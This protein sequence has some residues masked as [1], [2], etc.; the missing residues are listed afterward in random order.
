[1]ARK[2]L[3]ITLLIFIFG[4]NENKNIF[5]EVEFSNIY[6]MALSNNDFSSLEPNREK[7]L[8]TVDYLNTNPILWEKFIEDVNLKI[9]K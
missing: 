8:N 6:A 1:M 4:C 7:I 9:H 5:S 2:I 3:G